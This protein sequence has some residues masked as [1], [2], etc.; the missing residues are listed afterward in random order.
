MSIPFALKL[1]RTFERHG[2][3]KL[4]AEQFLDILRGIGFHMNTDEA[5]KLVKHL[6]I[7][8]DG[9]LDMDTFCCRFKGVEDE[10]H[11]QHSS[12]TS[13]GVASRTM[14]GADVR[15][16]AFEMHSSATKAFHETECMIEVDGLDE[17]STAGGVE[18]KDARA[19][20]ASIVE[21]PNGDGS[22]GKSSV[23]DG[24]G[25][26]HNDSELGAASGV[27]SNHGFRVEGADEIYG[28]DSDDA[29]CSP[30]SRALRVRFSQEVQMS[31]GS[32]SQLGTGSTDKSTLSARRLLPDVEH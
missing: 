12:M 13:S 1:N 17:L 27:R 19:A 18:T 24:V 23:G 29:S 11:D 10:L 16:D 6:G 4:T 30:R 25:C 8:A 7:D 20:V 22:D 15:S 3:R 9:C 28:H 5:A 31:S 26:S 2:V 21:V 14:C 32:I